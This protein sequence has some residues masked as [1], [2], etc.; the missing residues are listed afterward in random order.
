VHFPSARGRKCTP[1]AGSDRRRDCA[2]TIVEHRHVRLP[3]SAR[4][5]DALSM[6]TH[7]DNGHRAA[8]WDSYFGSSSGATPKGVP[9]WDPPPPSQSRSPWQP[10]RRSARRPRAGR[11]LSQRRAR[12]QPKLASFLSACSILAVALQLLH[13]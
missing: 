12:L 7:E 3:T 8:F 6:P 9:P 4:A 1:V 5:T 2:R 11:P 13:R 10:P